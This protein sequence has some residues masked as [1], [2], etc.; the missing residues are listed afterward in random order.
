MFC[1]RWHY[2]ITMLSKGLDMIGPPCSCPNTLTELFW[3]HLKP[4]M[5]SHDLKTW[6]ITFQVEE[7][8]QIMLT[9]FSLLVANKS[10]IIK[11]L[12]TWFEIFF[13]TLS[14]FHISWVDYPG[15]RM[16]CLLECL[17]F[18]RLREI[19]KHYFINLYSNTF[20]EDRR[21][22][23]WDRAQSHSAEAARDTQRP[24]RRF[25]PCWGLWPIQA[26]SQDTCFLSFVWVPSLNGEI[27]LLSGQDF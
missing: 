21:K 5:L 25:A 12:S 4:K 24:C 18:R 2:P 13:L 7:T 10:T 19:Y 26:Q 11:M 3:L 17:S 16:H 14:K 6:N 27:G 22:P 1:L 20:R 15:Q 23:P 9:A 8:S